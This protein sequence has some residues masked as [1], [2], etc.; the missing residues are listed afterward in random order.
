M[1]KKSIFIPKFKSKLTCLCIQ[2]IICQTQGLAK[3][4]TSFALVHKFLDT[5]FLIE[6]GS[7]DFLNVLWI[8]KK[9]FWESPCMSPECIFECA[10]NLIS[11]KC[12]WHFSYRLKDY[13]TQNLLMFILPFSC[14]IPY[15]YI[16]LLFLFPGEVKY[17]LVYK[18]H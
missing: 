4:L 17:I 10:E 14:K 15:S 18:Y 6:Y 11:S 1:D 7:Q 12:I 8:S 2:F 3:G 16:Y 13:I 9:K 5:H